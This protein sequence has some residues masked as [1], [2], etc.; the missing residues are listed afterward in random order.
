M[1][2]PSN[3]TLGQGVVYEARL[4]LAW[5]A[6]EKLPGEQSL[7]SL[8]D[9][10]ESVLRSVLSLEEVINEHAEEGAVAAQELGRIEAKVNLVLDL[11]AQLIAV[12]SHIPPKAAVCLGAD[13][14]E[15]STAMVPQPGQWVEVEIYLHPSFPRALRLVGEV[16]PATGRLPAP[17]VAVTFS[18]LSEPVQDALEKLIFR[19]HRRTVA[20]SRA[21]RSI[22]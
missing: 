7:L 20:Q 19:H 11:L 9:H 3:P 18:G 4:P 17:A 5:Q 14:L 22:S 8:N 21:R 10:N 13:F 2:A 12:Q 15:W 1:N 16:H 6:I